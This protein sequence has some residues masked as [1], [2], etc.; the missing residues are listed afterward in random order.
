MT[1]SRLGSLTKEKTLEEYWLF[2]A[3]KSTDLGI[4]ATLSE[5]AIDHGMRKGGE[6]EQF[7]A[8][9]YY[10]PADLQAVE[11]EK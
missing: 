5:R 8:Q 10:Y 7:L 3:K 4:C 2:Q 9:D 6:R 1:P 11:K